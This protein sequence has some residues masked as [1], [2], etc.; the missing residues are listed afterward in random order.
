MIYFSTRVVY[1]AVRHTQEVGQFPRAGFYEQLTYLVLW[2]SWVE[3][4]QE[5]CRVI[6]IYHIGRNLNM[7]Y[8]GMILLISF[9][10]NIHLYLRIRYQKIKYYL[11]RLILLAYLPSGFWSRLLTRILADDS[12]VEILRSYFIIPQASYIVSKRINYLKNHSICA[13][14]NTG[15]YTSPPPGLVAYRGT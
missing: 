10:R 3:R 13:C 6:M 9:Q 15:S 2:I 12:V 8:T 1:P 14:H 7:Q 11:F 4:K 5:K